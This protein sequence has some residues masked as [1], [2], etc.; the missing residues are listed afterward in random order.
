MGQA[1]AFRKT[2]SI[3][4][5]LADEY[6]HPSD[7]EMAMKR[8]LVSQQRL[9]NKTLSRNELNRLTDYGTNEVFHAANKLVSQFKNNKEEVQSKIIHFV[10]RL[11]LND[12]EIEV[13]KAEK[14]AKSANYE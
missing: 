10:M 14:V 12:A 11:K 1:S 2:S 3:I 6:M 7:V 13:D 4:Y 5:S 8:N 9:Q